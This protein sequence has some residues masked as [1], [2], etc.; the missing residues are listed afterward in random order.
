MSNILPLLWEDK[1]NNP[2]LLAFLE[3][4]GTKEYLAAIEINQLRDGLNELF[5]KISQAKIY[6][7]GE[8]QIFRKPGTAPDP[9]NKL[10]NLGDWCIGFMEGQFINATYLGGNPLLL[11]SY[12]I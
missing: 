10:P 6:E 3:Q 5:L 2:E 4:Y 11:T 1:V 7:N 9:E 12:D 8:M